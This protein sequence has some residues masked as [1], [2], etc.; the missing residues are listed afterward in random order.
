VSKTKTTEAEQRRDFD[1]NDPSTHHLYDPFLHGTIELNGMTYTGA[2]ATLALRKSSP[3]SQERDADRRVADRKAVDAAKLKELTE[4]DGPWLRAW[5]GASKTLQ[6]RKREAEAELAAAIE[7]D[8][9]AS[10]FARVMVLTMAYERGRQVA[11]AKNDGF[12]RLHSRPPGFGESSS[13]GMM[14]HEPFSKVF[15]RVVTRMAKEWSDDVLSETIA[16]ELPD[17]SAEK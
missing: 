15:E 7:A 6:S 8:P 10:A 16:A 14:Q 9:A 1:I 13:A 17:E 11:A 4:R 2:A 12:R 5:V 3:A